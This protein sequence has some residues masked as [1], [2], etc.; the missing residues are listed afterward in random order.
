MFVFQQEASIC[1]WRNVQTKF[2]SVLVLVYKSA[3]TT[4][5][6]REMVEK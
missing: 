1:L 4:A 6:C 3:Q 2:I 5:E